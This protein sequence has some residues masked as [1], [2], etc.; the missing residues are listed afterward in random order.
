MKACL[1]KGQDHANCDQLVVHVASTSMSIVISWALWEVRRMKR[2]IHPLLLLAVT[3]GPRRRV[4]QRTLTSG[5][6]QV[7]SRT[8][9]PA[10]VEA[11]G[12]AQCGKSACCVRRGGGWKRGRV[13]MRSQK[14][15]ALRSSGWCGQNVSLLMD[16]AVG[17]AYGLVQVRSPAHH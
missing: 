4:A 2:T 15:G 13:E 11:N 6:S 17:V 1:R 12:G 3:D 16:L 9:A 5:R 10:G 14:I 7:G 8:G